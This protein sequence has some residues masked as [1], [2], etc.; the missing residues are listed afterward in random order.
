MIVRSSDPLG[1]D[2]P[3]SL[4]PAELR[5][6][7]D[8]DVRL[9]GGGGVLIGG[10]PSRLI[11]LT[12]AG[13][14]H[15]RRWRAGDTIGAGR[16]ARA[17]A[18]RL[19][20]AGLL[21]PEP[22]PTPTSGL[23]VIVPVHGR[24]VQ[25]ARCLAAISRT[26]PNAAVLVIDDGSRD[27]AAI[28]RV[29]S[30]Y[31]ARV[32]RHRTSR[33]PGAAR[34]T[35]YAESDSPL[36]A[37]VDSDVVLETGCLS[38]LAGQFADPAVG[39]AAPRV[40]AADRGPGVVASYE[41]RHSSLDM[42]PRPSRVAPGTAVPYVPATTLVLR[43]EAFGPGF[44]ERL[45]A[46]EDVDFVW[47]LAAAGWTVRYDPAVAVRHMH[48]TSPRELAARRFTYANSIGA[49]A[50]RHPAAL[51]AL[52]LDLATGA[53][54]LLLMRR[55]ALA[56]ALATVAAARTRATLRGRAPQPTRLAIE[57]TGQSLRRG[58]RNL[59]HAIRR[60]WW[61]LA[62]L[63]ASRRRD[64]AI[65]LAGAWALGVAEERPTRPAHA[66]LCILEDMIAGAGT[67]WSCVHHRTAVPLL[68]S[69][70]GRVR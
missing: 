41:A 17:L 28:A 2:G 21:L 16:A 13:A 57:L 58:G 64:A 12:S 56:L 39:A 7:L 33:G 61:P 14:A 46:G 37:Y 27:A 53:V 43:R 32:I 47:R 8:P 42:G 44:D 24:E 50:A 22:D 18:R 38:R 6:R 45:H 55:P 51:P 35:G 26:A 31:G 66:A 20:D 63:A 40:L 19:L 9:R 68:P 25:L 49:L 10:V 69:R 36:L 54:A 4:P 5:V 30:E 15:V 48:R 34:N 11:R 29:A 62:A 3:S 59:A 23:T 65:V 60:P 1:P 52:R 67:W 70:R